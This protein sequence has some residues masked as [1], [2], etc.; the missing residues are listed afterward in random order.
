MVITRRPQS[1]L[2]T[3]GDAPMSPAGRLPLAK[4]VFR[5]VG[6]RRRGEMPGFALPCARGH[7][8]SGHPKAALEADELIDQRS[9]TSSMRGDPGKSCST[10]SRTL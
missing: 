10:P 8:P 5:Q 9:T 2:P 4:A 1:Y 3:I 7:P 6:I